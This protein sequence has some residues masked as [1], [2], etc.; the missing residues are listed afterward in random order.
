MRGEGTLTRPHSCAA[1]REREMVAMSA[2]VAAPP[3][4]KPGSTGK[5]APRKKIL[6]R[7]V[8]PATM[9]T[10]TSTASILADESSLGMAKSSSRGGSGGGIDFVGGLETMAPSMARPTP[11]EMGPPPPASE[12][13]V[14]PKGPALGPDGRRQDWAVLG[15]VGEAKRATTHTH[16]R[17]T[18]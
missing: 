16:T 7:K 11:S 9:T 3:E 18:T 14:A 1:P 8:K 17:F 5:P 13:A 15:D 2:E 6:I 10:Q 12:A 4:P